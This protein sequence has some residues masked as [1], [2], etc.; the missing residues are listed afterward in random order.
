MCTYMH[1]LKQCTLRHRQ[2]HIL[3][4]TQAYTCTQANSQSN[5]YKHTY[6][7]TC[8]S[9]LHTRKH[10]HSSPHM[11][12]HSHWHTHTYVH[13][14]KCMD[15]CADTNTLRGRDFPCT[16]PRSTPPASPDAPA[17]RI[18]QFLA[19]LLVWCHT[20]QEKAAPA[21][22]ASPSDFDLEGKGKKEIGT[23]EMVQQGRHLPST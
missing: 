16:L 15:E 11:H 6:T 19:Q 14:G 1:A 10:T 13:T 22:T 8:T 21:P 17:A 4:C 18:S 20:A 2:R 3:T 12:I 23:R 9:T 5:L 7:H